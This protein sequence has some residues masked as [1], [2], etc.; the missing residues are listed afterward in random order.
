MRLALQCVAVVDTV[1]F[2]ATKQSTGH[3][4]T[5]RLGPYVRL[6]LLLLTETCF[7]AL[8]SIS[9]V[10]GGF[11]RVFLL[12]V[13]TYVGFAFVMTM[14]LDD[15]DEKVPRCAA[16]AA[17]KGG[18]KAVYDECPDVADG[19]STF[20]Q[21]VYT[22]IA[23]TNANV[24]AQ[25]Y[26]N[27]VEPVRPHALNGRNSGTTLSRRPSRAQAARILWIAFYCLANIILLNLML[28]VVYNA[29]SGGLKR[30]IFNFF[31]Q[32]ARGLRVAYY[33]LLRGQKLAGGRADGVEKERVKELVVELN[34]SCVTPYLP[35]SHFDFFF[36]VWTTTARARSASTSSASSATISARSTCTSTSGVA[37]GQV[38]AAFAG[39]G[40][41]GEG[42]AAVGAGATFILWVMGLNGVCVLLG[43]GPLKLLDRHTLVPLRSS[44]DT[45]AL[46][47]FA[48]ASDALELVA[49][50]V[51][52]VASGR[53]AEN[54]LSVD[55]SILLFSVSLAYV[56]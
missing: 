26:P 22:T 2:V 19:F 39:G 56:R 4:A 44:F 21:G 34:K 55:S 13:A 31:R 5:V 45:W 28:A 43:V 8:K 38:P 47:E 33:E 52:P 6:L 51:S 37:G 3:M 18:E 16:L 15:V 36:D 54:K 41:E 50:C 17:K 10:L 11:A 25:A 29:Y 1:V 40:A 46:I 49:R 32:R 35:L 27:Y 14:V 30:R 23:A 42:V 20:W 12:L 48:F 7:T 9:D 53:V 24:P